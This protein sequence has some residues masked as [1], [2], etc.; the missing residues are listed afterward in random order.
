MSQAVGDF[1]S[2]IADAKQIADPKSIT[3]NTK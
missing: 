3:V 2:A 1:V